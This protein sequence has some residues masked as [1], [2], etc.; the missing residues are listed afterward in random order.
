M[1]TSMLAFGISM[2]PAVRV[3]HAVGRNDA[4][5]TKRA[6]LVATLLGTLIAALLTVAV[7][8]APLEIAELFLDKSAKMPTQR[9]D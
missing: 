7:I 3:G 6:G 2:G 1:I 4:L 8:V 9:S 5:G